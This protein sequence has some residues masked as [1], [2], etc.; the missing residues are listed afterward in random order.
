MCGILGY[1]GLEKVDRTRRAVLTAVLVSEMEKRGDQSF[2]SCDAKTGE[3]KKAVG[4]PTDVADPVYLSQAETLIGHTRFATTGEISEEN[5]HPFKIKGSVC[6]VI[7][8]HNG[9]VFNHG[10]LAAKHKR[11]LSVDSMWIFDAIANGRDL[12]EVSGYGAIVYQRSDE[13]ERIYMGRS[14][15]G[16]LY[17]YGV[18]LGKDSP[19]QGIIWASTDL[20]VKKAIA[21]SGVSA[22]PYAVK[23]G[24]LYWAEKGA[25]YKSTEGEKKPLK[26]MES[27]ALFDSHS[28][29]E[30]DSRYD[31]LAFEEGT[32]D[33]LRYAVYRK[34]GG[35][36]SFQEWQSWG[37]PAVPLNSLEKGDYHRRRRIREIAEPIKTLEPLVKPPVCDGC[38]T[39]IVV[40][41][42]WM[43]LN[44]EI[45]CGKC[46][47]II[48]D[49]TTAN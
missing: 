30:W 19:A 28:W 11:K 38:G 49:T 24:V 35:S 13:P 40:R 44:S 17:V 31:R 16:D 18:G 5:A 43:P 29:M 15:N 23:R 8:V 20:A 25:F 7:G 41:D 22:A 27:K 9:V 14:G 45:Y 36:F 46:A 3:I 26:K 12:S 21:L 32:S 4:T 39:V 47:A 37:R 48:P 6:T 33:G 10:V 42:G 34:K 2:G 1:Q